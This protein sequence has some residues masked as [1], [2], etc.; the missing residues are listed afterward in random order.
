[1]CVR[2]GGQAVEGFVPFDQDGVNQHH[3]GDLHRLG[4]L[5]RHRLRELL[6]CIQTHPA[7]QKLSDQ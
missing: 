3:S 2:S 7:Q 1:M 4:H 5:H 6:A